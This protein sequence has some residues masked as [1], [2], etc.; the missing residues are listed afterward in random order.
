M[1][2][3]FVQNGALCNAMNYRQQGEL[4]YMKK[5]NTTT[6]Y[7]QRYDKDSTSITINVSVNVTCN[8]SYGDY[9]ED[10]YTES[11]RRLAGAVHR[12]CSL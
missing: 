3:C 6:W 9:C 12:G 5:E 8:I 7:R 4:K 11:Y 1:V 2:E 10:E